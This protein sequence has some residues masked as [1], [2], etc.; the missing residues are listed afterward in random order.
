MR[1]SASK[2]YWLQVCRTAAAIFLTV[3]FLGLLIT[4]TAFGIFTNNRDLLAGV[5]K[6]L[7][8]GIVFSCT[9]AGGTSLTRRRAD[10]CRNFHHGVKVPGCDSVSVDVESHK[11]EGA[12]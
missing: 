9:W 6:I 1:R 8:Y 2:P 7:T 12:R 10:G 4:V 11:E 3:G 5:L